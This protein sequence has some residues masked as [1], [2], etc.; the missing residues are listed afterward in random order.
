[1]CNTSFAPQS[2]C[3]FFSFIASSLRLLPFQLRDHYLASPG[4]A[5]SRNH[6]CEAMHTGPA[7]PLSSTTFTR[8]ALPGLI[9][10]HADVERPRQQ[11]APGM[12]T[13]RSACPRH[14]SAHD[15]C[16]SGRSP[17]NSGAGDKPDRVSEEYCLT[18]NTPADV[19]T[20]H[21]KLASLNMD[22][23]D[24]HKRV[25]QEINLSPRRV[26][27]KAPRYQDRKMTEFP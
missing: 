18:L 26:H 25:H 13:D 4:P 5:I 16:H 27:Y 20:G 10:N 1:M 17:C 24:P 3:D 8:T 11:P 15:T 7:R 19:C 22:R 6:H 21:S 14:V 9:L 23:P 2:Q 12:A